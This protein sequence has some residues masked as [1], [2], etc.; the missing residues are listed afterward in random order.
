MPAKC[1]A[2]IMKDHS[3]VATQVEVASS[4]HLQGKNL[5]HLEIPLTDIKLATKNFNDAYLIGS[6]T[7]GK[8]Y[9]AELDLPRQEENQRELSDRIKRTVAIKRILNREDKHGKQGFV[10]EIDLLTN[11]KHPNIVSLLG[12]CHE[13]SH[14]ILVYEFASN[15]SLGDYLGSADNLIYLTWVQR[16]KICIDIARGLNYLH[17]RV[18]DERRIIH[19]DIKSDN[20][21]LGSNWEGK[22]ADFGL[23]RFHPEKEANTIYTQNIAGTE[24]YLDPEYEKTGKLKKETDIYSF[25]VVLFEILSG[26]IANDSTYY[27]EDNKGLAPVARRHFKE[28]T[29]NEMV[30]AKIMEEVDELS[31]TLNKGPNQDSLNMFTKIAF[32]CL[33]ETQVG[34]P[35]AEVIMKELE[36]ALSF[37]ENHKDNLQIALEDVKKAT[38]NFSHWN[39]IG[40]GGFGKVYEGQ[41]THANG[42]NRIVAKRLDKSQGQGEHEFLTELEILFEYKHENIIGLVGYCN[43]KDEKI[44]VYEHASNGSLDKHLRHISFTWMKRLKICIDIASGLS[45]LHGGAQT[46]E[47]VIHSDIKSA[48]I[49]VNDEWKAKISDFGL[50]TIIPIDQEMMYAICNLVGTIGYVDPMYNSTGFLAKESDIYSFGV[51]LFEILYGKLLV[52]NIRNFDQQSVTKILN[53]IH[54]EENLNWIVLYG[55]RKQIAPKSLST[56]R[57]IVS[58]CLD[59]DRKKRPTA[60]EVLRQLNIAMEFQEDYEVWEPKLPKGYEEI[61]Q[62]SKSRDSWSAKKKKDLCEMFSEG[63]L[64]LDDKVEDYEVWEPKLP[65]GYEEIIQMSKSRD[66][67]SAKKKKDLCEMFSEG[68]PLLET[69]WWF[70]VGGN[71]ER[72]KMISAS[73]FSYINESSPHEWQSTPESKLIVVDGLDETE[74]GY[75]G[76][77]LGEVVS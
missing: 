75:R 8:V 5:G 49:L 33:A 2:D 73:E 39:L 28:G 68:H 51:V 47:M 30:D 77:C 71:G 9:K 6:G 11:C 52:P 21:L 10:A 19:R 38:R 12:F 57:L 26:K 44:I 31:S 60:E 48:N 65:K 20:I 37:Q 13:G 43:E 61:I 3:K 50:S 14:M 76:R 24:V 58:Q 40:G 62:M 25:G 46:K 70:S 34:R 54:D 1:I 22:I 27:A 17:T 7:Y 55:I 74:R 45:F 41:L 64:L 59:N 15:G 69:K 66:S 32:Q 23:S 67:W 29:I 36:K 18:E 56:F 16:L 4:N 72:N 53:Y 63:L 42:C 35:T